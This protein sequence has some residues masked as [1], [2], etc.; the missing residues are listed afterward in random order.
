MRGRPGETARDV[1]VRVSWGSAESTGRRGREFVRHR[2]RATAVGA[3]LGFIVLSAGFGAAQTP[4]NFEQVVTADIRMASGRSVIQTL[5]QETTPLAEIAVRAVTQARWQ[6]NGNERFEVLEAFTRKADG[7]I[8]PADPKDFVTQDGAVGAAMSFVDLKVQQVA[9][10]DVAVGDT[11][12]VTVRIHKDEHYIPGQYSDAFVVLPGPAKRSID[13]T[14]RAPAALE[15]FHDERQLAYEERKDGDDT[16]R[17]WSGSFPPSSTDEK[18][19]VN[20]T[21]HVP[22]LQF[23]T[24]PS[25][26][27]IATAYYD[28]ANARLAVTPEIARLADEITQ[29]KPDVRAQTQALFEWVSRNIRYV[30]VYFGNGRYV[31]NDGTTILSR[32]FGDCKDHAALLSALLAAKGI[33]SE[34]VL[35][36]TGSNYELARTPTLQAFNHVIVYVPALDRY[37]DPTVPFGSFDHLPSNAMGK[38]VVRVSEKG[39]KLARTPAPAVDDNVVELDTR[40]SVTRDGRRQGQTAI[41][42]RGEF[43]DLLRGFVALSEAKGKE[44]EL[45]ELA[46]LRALEGTFAMDAPPWT[47]TRE[48]FRVTT[49]WDQQQPIQAGWRAPVGFSPL[50][51]NPDLFFGAL[52]ANKRSYPGFCRP[53]RFIHTLDAT[54][55]DGIALPAQLPAAIKQTTPQFSFRHAWS[56]QGNHLKLRTEIVSSV[57][58]RVCSAGEIDA[59]SAAYRPV[60]D[61]LGLTLRFAPRQIPAPN[62]AEV[63][64]EGV[65]QRLF[66]SRPGG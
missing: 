19:I 25:F 15:I 59:V 16:V 12:V 52:D 51:A 28:A 8:V 60:Q 23:S 48:P 32:R 22:G 36:G 14:L 11:T 27:A 3:A 66:G 40:V 44:L 5:H 37:L 1:A 64:H 26:E 17:H 56:R 6:I 45:R 49:R 55:A 9:F 62:P 34:Q 46:K 57:Q 24:F 41:I 39:A 13:V 20:L 33:V 35:I 53:G 50:V 61:R 54:F 42:A 29:G 30:A 58:G 2:H 10:R 7:R 47:E 4:A 43:A 38:P 65:L 31:P 63:H 21:F 18:N